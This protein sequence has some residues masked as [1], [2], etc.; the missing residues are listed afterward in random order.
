MNGILL[1]RIIVAAVISL[2][3]LAI[4]F[5][6]MDTLGSRPSQVRQMSFRESSKAVQVSQ[7]EYKSRE[8]SLSTLGR[9]ISANAVDVIS[10]VQG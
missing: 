6:L 4:G 1:R 10:E 9:V 7:V 3:I 2:V 8:I 5:W